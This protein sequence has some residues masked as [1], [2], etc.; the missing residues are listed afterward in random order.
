MTLCFLT[1]WQSVFLQ[2]LKNKHPKLVS[3]I[4]RLYGYC[5]KNEHGKSKT[6]EEFSN[7]HVYST[8][9]FLDTEDCVI[10]AEILQITQILPSNAHQCTEIY[11]LYKMKQ[12]S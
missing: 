9:F 11:H 7:T 1:K 2:I 12:Y 6:K 10:H 4:S 3:C 8:V 5:D